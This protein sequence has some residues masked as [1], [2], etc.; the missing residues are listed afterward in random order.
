MKNDLRL[1]NDYRKSL[2]KDFRKHAEQEDNAHK[3]AYL[4]SISDFDMAIANA[5]K[6]AT[7]V[8][9]RAFIPSDVAQLR[10]LQNKYS[11]VDSVATDSCF[12]F[13]VVDSEGTNWQDTAKRDY[14]YSY[15]E[16]Q[17]LYPEKHFSFELNGNYTGERYG[18]DSDKFMFAYYRDELSGL[19]FNPDIEVEQKDNSSNPHLTTAREKMNTYLKKNNRL[20]Q[21]KNKYSLWI[22][23]TGGCRSRAIKCTRQEFDV[24]QSYLHS[25]QAV[26]Q[27]HEK[28]IEGILQQ[29]EVVKN[30]IQSYKNLSSVKELADTLGWTVNEH[31][32]AQKGTDLVMSSPDSIKS[33]LDNI[34]GVKQTREEKILAVMKY[35]KEKALAN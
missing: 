34:K 27:C 2:I 12:Y 31:I 10:Q 30:A 23:G 4:Q 33:M 28:W 13:K 18:Y 17:D 5:F 35:N 1:N 6:T 8:V 21:W 22:I 16:E 7:T 19:G 20:D 15:N 14:G 29:V 3:D 32:L 9:E 26:V 25:K 24:M 11:T